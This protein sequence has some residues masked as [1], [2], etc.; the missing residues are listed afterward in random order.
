MSCLP[1]RVYHHVGESAAYV[2][3]PTEAAGRMLRVPSHSGEN[4]RFRDSQV[5]ILAR[6]PLGNDSSIGIRVCGAKTNSPKVVYMHGRYR[7]IYSRCAEYII[8]GKKTEHSVTLPT[9][10]RR[11]GKGRKED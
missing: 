2:V 8:C 6:L 10:K 7:L 3:Y 11:R 4:R 5:C 1:A 9:C